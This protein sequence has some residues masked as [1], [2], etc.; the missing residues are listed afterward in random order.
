[1]SILVSC[2]PAPTPYHPPTP[3][4]S[5]PA[6]IINVEI[7]APAS[8]ARFTDPRPNIIFILTDDQ[9]EHTVEYMPTVKNELMA[10]GVVFENGFAT[11]PLCCPSRASILSGQ[12]AHNHQVLNNT[13]PLGGATKFR[14]REA[15]PLWLQDAGYR[16]AYFGKYMN[17]YEDL[18][19]Y[20]YVPPG[21][22]TWK[23]FLSKNLAT[24][25]D[26]GNMQY[27]FD[28]SMSENGMP[29]AYPKSKDNFSADVVTRNA[30]EFIRD[31][32]DA[33]FMLALGY[34]NP[35]S[36]YISAPRHK[37]TFRA[38]ADYWDWVQYR[39]P[40]FNE[41]D[42]SDKPEYISQLSPLSPTEID[43]AHKQI[44]RS[45]LSVD[46]GVASILSAL[47]KAGL[48]DNT[49]VVYMSDNGMTMG[50]HRFGVTK[51]CPYEACVKVPFIVY[52]PAYFQPRIEKKIAANIDIAP[53]FADL[54]GASIPDTVDGLSLVPL[55]K[56]S[57]AAWR[58]GIL[59][60]HWPTNEGIGSMIPEFYSIRTADWKYV[61][62]STGETELY[63]LVNDP[64]ELQNLSGQN[65]YQAIQAELAAKLS[66]LKRE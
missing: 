19:P 66:A 15:F 56:D 62:Y 42:I 26:Q 27:Y 4:L 7:E 12:Y 9:P 49:V 8:A 59:L 30:L 34:Y 60:E 21:W 40:N 17:A 45:L 61:E 33:P 37:D 32:R 46:D 5:H 58:D 23:A 16:T 29:V 39:P 18:Q 63:D 35:H 13:L 28:F 47:E 65:A 3:I 53:T 64:Y 44:L 1:L 43:T 24:V 54:A 11:T 14:D 52:A 55:L 25:E 22:D 50:D 10:K 38:G 51:N 48:G 57:S 6:T 20:G 2:A 41:A 36:P 31:A